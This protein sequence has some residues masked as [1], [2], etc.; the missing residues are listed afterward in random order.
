MKS[1]TEIVVKV[2]AYFGGELNFFKNSGK[3]GLGI[4]VSQIAP[5]LALPFL[6]R[7]YDPTA[8]GW[9]G[10]Y[11]A[12]S[13]ILGIVVSG[14]FEL[15]IL[16]QENEEFAYR[17]RKLAEY[18][19]LAVTSV[20]ILLVLFAG[21]FIVS[22]LAMKPIAWA[23]FLVPFN[24]AVLGLIQVYIYHHNRHLRYSIIAKSKV[25]Y[26]TS[27]I[28][29]QLGIGLLGLTDVGL[30]IGFFVGT[31][32]HALAL[33]FQGVKSFRLKYTFNYKIL[34]ATFRENRVMLTQNAPHAT[35]NSVAN[36]VPFFVLNR[37]FSEAVTGYYLMAM[38][39]I[40]MP[41][42]LVSEAISNVFSQRAVVLSK[43]DGQLRPFMVNLYTILA[44]IG[45][46]PFLVIALFGQTIFGILFGSEW[47]EAGLFASILSPALF[48]VLIV[49][50]TSY[51]P[52]IFDEQY[53]AFVLGVIYAVLRLA[54]LF[55]GVYFDNYYLCIMLY[56]LV[57]CAMQAYYLTWYL[58]LAKT[59]QK[60]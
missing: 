58:R 13:S 26:S 56:S 32:A 25:I 54:A 9:L 49:G 16:L 33:R 14:R 21:D 41:I 36:N 55:I 4:A 24:A 52:I 28:V 40:Q 53:R 34:V 47:V 57:I 8:F 30:I 11:I 18:F 3:I 29:F 23:L 20:L 2:K 44:L 38:R 27:L 5:I 31:A 6:T 60:A 50:P 7:I 39:L 12:A 51:V 1:L 17:V 19:I 35:I 59:I 46:T 45:F 22:S 43:S 37:F 42:Q 48:L 15:S 10:I